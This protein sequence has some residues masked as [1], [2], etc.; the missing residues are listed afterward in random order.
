[1][2]PERARILTCGAYRRKTAADL[3]HFAQRLRQRENHM[4][5]PAAEFLGHFAAPLA[6]LRDNPLYQNFRC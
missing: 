2:Q 5:S 6:K 4:L 3:D 1:V